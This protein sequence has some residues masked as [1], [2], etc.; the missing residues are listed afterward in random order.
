MSVACASLTPAR[1]SAAFSLCPHVFFDFNRVLSQTCLNERHRIALYAKFEASYYKVWTILNDEGR[2]DD[3]G[4]GPSLDAGALI[5]AVSKMAR[6]FQRVYVGSE[7]VTTLNKAERSER[8]DIKRRAI[9]FF[10]IFSKQIRLND[11][12]QQFR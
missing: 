1:V 9:A 3:L 6:L 11:P 12:L 10:S 8:A 7:H 2:R 4:R 5:A